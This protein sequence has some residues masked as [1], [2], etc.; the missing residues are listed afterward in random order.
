MSKPKTAPAMP[1]AGSKI[2]ADCMRET[3]HAQLKKSGRHVGSVCK[4]C[5][6]RRSRLRYAAHRDE[7]RARRRE[8]YQDPERRRRHRERNRVRARSRRGRQLNALAVAR[9]QQRNPYKVAAA[10]MLKA[11]LKRG[12]VVRP[13]TCQ[14]HGCNAPAEHGHHGDYARPL[15]V[16]HLCRPCHESTHHQG[17][18]RL[19][20]GAK[21]KFARAPA[22]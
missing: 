22:T 20:P 1:A 9:W 5:D 6:A 18:Q 7:I 16:V 12:T 11:T 14:A 17:P 2:C 3:P 15:D 19:K 13:S 4:A 10:R 21:R 8:L